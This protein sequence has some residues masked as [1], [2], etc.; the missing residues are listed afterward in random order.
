MARRRVGGTGG[1][2]AGAGIFRPAAGWLKRM[3]NNPGPLASMRGNPAANF[4]GGRYNEITLPRDTT[5]YRG[6]QAG[7][8]NEFGRWFTADPPPSRAHVRVDSAVLPHWIDPKTGASSGSSPID[9]AYA[10]R[11]PAGT[12]IYHGPVAN[13]GGIYVGGGEQIY[14]PEPWKSGTVSGSRPLP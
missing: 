7:P 14:I 12:K 5:L 3:V 9:T 11:F 13:Q 8:G 1:A 2:G 6:G 4:A 10:I